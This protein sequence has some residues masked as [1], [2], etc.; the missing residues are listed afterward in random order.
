MAR[1]K[2]AWP[3]ICG[4]DPREEAGCSMTRRN[5]P[6]D[7]VQLPATPAVMMLCGFEHFCRHRAIDIDGGATTEP[8]AVLRAL[9]QEMCAR[10]AHRIQGIGLRCT[11]ARGVVA[12]RVQ[13]QV[14][15]E[16]ELRCIAQ[17]GGHLA[18]GGGRADQQ[19]RASE[20]ERIEPALPAG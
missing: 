16:S 20:R 15:R 2:G 11:A 19:V 7:Q 17:E 13:V 8:A 9:A 10:A 12:L 4:P 6:A 14:G 5:A 3:F 1:L 18:V